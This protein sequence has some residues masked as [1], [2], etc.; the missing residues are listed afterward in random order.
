MQINYLPEGGAVGAGERGFPGN[1]VYKAELCSQTLL[2]Q[3][4]Y[5]RSNENYNQNFLKKVGFHQKYSDIK[6]PA[7]VSIFKRAVLNQAP[8]PPPN[9]SNFCKRD[10]QLVISQIQENNIVGQTS[11][12]L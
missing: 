2:Y 1:A 9:H 10:L 7:G 4:L 8:P 5:A 12:S 11:R 3:T 6:T